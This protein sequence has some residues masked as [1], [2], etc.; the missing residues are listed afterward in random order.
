M[1]APTSDQPEA[2]PEA[3]VPSCG[4]VQR[5]SLED[6]QAYLE[7]CP[8]AMMISEVTGA[9]RAVNRCY[10][11]ETGFPREELIGKTVAEL[12]FYVDLAQ[13]DQLFALLK[14]QGQVR[15]FKVRLRTKVLGEFAG[16]VSASLIV[17]GGETLILSTTRNLSEMEAAQDALRKSEE[18]LRGAFQASLDPITLSRTDG[19]FVEVN[20]AFCEQSGYRREE[21]LGRTALHIGLWL[22]VSQREGFFAT[23]AAHG[24]V[25]AFEAEMVDREG[26]VRRCLLSARVTVVGGVPMVLTVT[27]DITKLMEAEDALRKSEEFFRTLVHGGVD[28]VGLAEKNGTLVEVNDAFVELTGYSREETIGKNATQLG[29]WDD[30]RQRDEMR[31][32]M[33]A[34]GAISNYALRI[35]RKDGSLRYCLI[36]GRR[37][38]IGGRELLFSSTKDVTELREAEEARRIGEQRLRTLVESA[39]EGVWIVGADGRISFVNARMCELLGLPQD[40]VLGRNPEDFG[41]PASLDPVCPLPTDGH[42]PS[43]DVQLARPD[44]TRCWAIMNSTPLLDEDGVCVGAVGLF[45]DISQ[46]KQMEEQ[47]VQACIRAEAADKV[48]SEFLSN[49]SHEIRTPLNGMLG[50]LQLMQGDSTAK[51]QASYIDNAVSAG[52]RLL[53]LLNDVLDFSKMEAGKVQLRCAPFQMSR[54]FDSVAA[55]FQV[56][57]AAKKLEL[58]FHLDESVPETLVGDEARI[59][60]ILFNLVGNAVKFTPSGSVLVE[61]WARPST[62]DGPGRVRVHMSVRDTGI[63]IPDDKIAHVF[64][65]FTQ[66]DGTFTRAYEG[67]GLGL[68]IVKRIVELMHG[69][70][71]VESEVDS[72]TVMHLHLL[73]EMPQ[74]AAQAASDAASGAESAAGAPSLRILLAEDDAT[75]QLVMRIILSRLGHKVVCVETGR[76]AVEALKENDFDCILMDIQMPEM[77]GVEAT[78]IIRTDPELARKSRIPII[79]LTAYAMRGDREKF[80][81]AGMDGH[82]PKPVEMEE[83]RRALRTVAEGLRRAGR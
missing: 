59:R 7:D 70:I 78:R 62:V 63:G 26:N 22:S 69:G 44:G 13:R 10:C 83:L 82:V 31:E 38:A 74:P 8:D 2:Q 71:A 29:L 21:V 12:G 68:A 30:L 64:R 43:R 65:R 35:R 33:L 54:L 51:E 61:A 1:P 23:L 49:M 79:A 53:S 40:Q 80:L 17:L 42:R 66:N 25:R 45:T 39:L 47:L 67:A 81:A 11:E 32:I 28:P 15:E 57:C 4:P 77:G 9:I 3:S 73:L 34:H 48:K 19:E 24:S 37:L 60:Q 5:P 41:L 6:Y 72:G 18:L 75:S 76:M 14:A 27:K 58:T 20:D 56:A 16:L 36:S 55:M 52:H 50:M 46:R